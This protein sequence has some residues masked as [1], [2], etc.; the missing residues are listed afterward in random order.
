MLRAGKAF[1][2][3]GPGTEDIGV[4]EQGKQPNQAEPAL[5]RALG[6]PRRLEILGYLTQKGGAEE[7]EL[8]EALDLTAPRAKYHLSVLHDADLIAQVEGGDQGRPG[9]YTWPR[10]PPGL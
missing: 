10:P 3:R 7:A 1:P 5:K 6:H 9:A 4:K 8:V 2:V